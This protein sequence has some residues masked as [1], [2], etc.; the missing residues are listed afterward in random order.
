[1]KINE[2]VCM[3]C[4]YYPLGL[5]RCVSCSAFKL[6]GPALGI[7]WV[8]LGGFL[9]AACEIN[10]SIEFNEGKIP[11]SKS[12]LMS[13]MYLD[14]SDVKH[15]NNN[16]RH[17]KLTRTIASPY[18]RKKEK[19]RRTN[20]ERTRNFVDMKECFENKLHKRCRRYTKIEINRIKWGKWRKIDR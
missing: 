6:M 12:K 19:V 2:K 11:F 5:L 18:N 8:S 1:M 20:N 9:R 13:K 3:E 14:V 17:F 4:V 15:A 16:D 10:T 7:Y